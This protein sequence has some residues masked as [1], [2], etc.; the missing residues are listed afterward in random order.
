MHDALL[1]AD[2]RIDLGL[3]IQIDVIP[4][5]IPVG[6]SLSQDG[7][8][9]IGH[10]FVHVGTLGLL[11]EAL[12]NGGMGRQVGTAHGQFDNLTARG[13]L[14]LTDLAQTAR[15]IVLSDTVQPM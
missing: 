7:F 10:V 15:K 9:L 13:C 12:D 5:L 6:K 2:Q 3:E 14:N 1:R 4:F 11:R 8:S